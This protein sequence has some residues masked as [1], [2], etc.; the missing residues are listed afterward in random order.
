MLFLFRLGRVV[1]L[2]CELCSGEQADRRNCREFPSR[3]GCHY[4]RLRR[5]KLPSLRRSRDSLRSNGAFARLPAR[6]SDQQ[7]ASYRLVVSN[8]ACHAIC[9]SHVTVCSFCSQT[10]GARISIPILLARLSAGFRCCCR[11]RFRL[12]AGGRVGR[13]TV[14]FVV[15]DTALLTFNPL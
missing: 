12:L 9:F 4:C 1:P 5:L 7:P 13:P 11:S 14:A 10:A 6:P 2:V 8:L 3:A 15:T